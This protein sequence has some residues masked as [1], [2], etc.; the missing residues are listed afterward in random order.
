MKGARDS[1]KTLRY[2]Y[3]YFLFIYYLF[4]DYYFLYILM[5]LVMNQ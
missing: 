1:K 3:S 5:S 4:S 2:R